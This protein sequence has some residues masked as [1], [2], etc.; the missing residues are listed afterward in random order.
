M[1]MPTVV[2]N[3]DIEATIWAKATWAPCVSLIYADIAEKRQKI[4]QIAVEAGT[5]VG[6]E[7]ILVEDGKAG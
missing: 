4:F 1:C 7:H 2:E 3:G 5:R 6:K